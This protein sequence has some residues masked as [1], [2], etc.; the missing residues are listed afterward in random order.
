MTDAH[1]TTREVYYEHRNEKET[2]LTFM[3]LWSMS[4]L[5]GQH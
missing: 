4:F 2:R 1:K 3:E 5:P